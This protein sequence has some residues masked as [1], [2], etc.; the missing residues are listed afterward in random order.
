MGE[1]FI[2]P[3]MIL[4]EGCRILATT[5]LSLLLPLTF[6]L[7]ARLCTARYF[8]A[9]SVQRHHDTTFLLATH[10]A[11]LFL[12]VVAFLVTFAALLHCLTGTGTGTGT[13]RDVRYN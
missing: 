8:L 10:L 4:K 13:A 7:L 3:P 9:V 1:E 2:R 6:L 5:F 12:S 11:A